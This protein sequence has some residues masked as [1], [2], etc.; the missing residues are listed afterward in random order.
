M[1]AIA[2]KDSSGHKQGD[3][4]DVSLESIKKYLKMFHF[5]SYHP[6][7]IPNTFDAIKDRQ[8]AFVHIDVALYQSAK[9]C[10]AFFYDHMVS[11][12][13]MIFDDYGFP[14]YEFAE[15]QAVDEFFKDKPE[16]TLSLRTGQCIAIKLGT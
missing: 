10:C 2:D 6:G 12:G 13:I 1:P 9:D 4:G 14:G 5:I 3:F 8:F 15:K 7:L 11:G 16:E